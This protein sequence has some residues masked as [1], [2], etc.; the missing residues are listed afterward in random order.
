MLCETSI[1]SSGGR[2]RP[3][4]LVATIMHNINSLNLNVILLCLE[5]QVNFDISDFSVSAIMAQMNTETDFRNKKQE[6]EKDTLLR[7]TK[8]K[9]LW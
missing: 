7:N 5:I 9:K 8:K 4:R 2:K 1:Y 3:P 6:E